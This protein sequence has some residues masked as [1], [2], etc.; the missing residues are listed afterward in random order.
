MFVCL[1]GSTLS[2][3]MDNS[4]KIQFH[5]YFLHNNGIFVVSAAFLTPKPMKIFLAFRVFS[6]GF[7]NCHMLEQFLIN[8]FKNPNTE[9][10]R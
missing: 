10:T 4:K 6:L 1:V 9:T 5:C 2:M 7:L 3:L 8:M